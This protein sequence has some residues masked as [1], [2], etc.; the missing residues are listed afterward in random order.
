MLT[1]EKLCEMINENFG[2]PFLV[3]G[4]V[5]AEVFT[6]EDGTKSMT[7]Q[8]GRRDVEIDENGEVLG[9]GTL[10]VVDPSSLVVEF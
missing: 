9:C 10:V 6:D 7:L 2:E 3:K 1:L 8:I 4:G 5:S